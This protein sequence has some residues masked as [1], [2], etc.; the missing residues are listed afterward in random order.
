MGP[1]AAAGIGNGSEKDSDAAV[2][3]EEG[4][5]CRGVY[6]RG[7][8]LLVREDD[9]VA[10]HAQ[11]QCDVVREPVFGAEVEMAAKTV[12]AFGE[13]PERFPI[14]GIA[15]TGVSCSSHC[16]PTCWRMTSSGAM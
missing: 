2:D 4:D 1:V 12:D 15:D 6:I 10:G 3:R 8:D 7:E 11:P 16:L 14:G 5:A 13:F 9:P